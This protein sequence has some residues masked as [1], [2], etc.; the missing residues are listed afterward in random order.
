MTSA[1][2]P[3]CRKRELFGIPDGFEPL[4]VLALGYLASPDVL[5]EDLG[6]RERA[7]RVR[8]PLDALVFAGGWGQTSALFAG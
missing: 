1:R 2:Q 4:T 7:P 3:Y 8:K 5:P 6:E